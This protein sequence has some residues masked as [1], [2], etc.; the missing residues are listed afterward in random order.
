MI[1]LIANWPVRRRMH[2]DVLVQARS[3]ENQCYFVAVNRIGSGNGTPHDGGSVAYSPWGECLGAAGEGDAAAGDV[4]VVAIDSEEVTRVRT[5]Y[6]F[7]H[8][9]RPITA[10]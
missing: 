2:W 3:I 7:V 1:F 9:C 10:S 8:D 5:R 6:P 4:V